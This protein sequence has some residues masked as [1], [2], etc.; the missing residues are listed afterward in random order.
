MKKFLTRLNGVIAFIAILL[1]IS[2]AIPYF[3][4]HQS[5]I[6]GN[7]QSYVANG[8][9]MICCV[10]ILSFQLLFLNIKYLLNDNEEDYE[11]DT[12]NLEDFEETNVN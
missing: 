5:L 3:G 7:I 10:I 2:A 6:I 8:I 9:V 4:N 11:E 12:E 1:L